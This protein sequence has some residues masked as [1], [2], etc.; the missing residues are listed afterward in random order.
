MFEEQ[1]SRGVVDSIDSAKMKRKQTSWPRMSVKVR[2]FM[3]INVSTTV[4]SIP[5]DE[6]T[7]RSN[8]TV[9]SHNPID[10][11]PSHGNEGLMTLTSTMK[12]L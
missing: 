4:T 2:P 10:E 3:C 8:V 12:M 7:S 11:W 6:R 1:I 5:A 9:Y